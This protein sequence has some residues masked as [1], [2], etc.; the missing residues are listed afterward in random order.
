[1]FPQKFVLN[2]DARIQQAQIVHNPNNH[3]VFWQP[4]QDSYPYV[5]E[6]KV[7]MITTINNIFKPILYIYKQELDFSSVL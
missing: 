5:G 2:Y 7:E 1:M 3:I 4:N 6:F